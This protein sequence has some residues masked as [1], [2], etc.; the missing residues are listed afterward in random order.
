[1]FP[2]KIYITHVITTTV[3]SAGNVNEVDSGV[4]IDVLK[5]FISEQDPVLEWSLYAQRAQ[6]ESQR[7]RTRR[8][9]LS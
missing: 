4:I 6:E 8:G 1:M 9:S 3:R 7:R 2:F 5:N